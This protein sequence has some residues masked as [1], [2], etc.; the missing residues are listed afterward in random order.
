MLDDDKLLTG[1][2]LKDLLARWRVATDDDSIVPA[3]IGSEPDN[4]FRH[5]YMAVVVQ[6]LADLEVGW[7]Y[8]QGYL[9]VNFFNDGDGGPA[10]RERDLPELEA[11]FLKD[12]PKF[13]YTSTRKARLPDWW[14]D[15]ANPG[16]IR[17]SGRDS[18]YDPYTGR[19]WRKSGPLFET[20][21]FAVEFEPQIPFSFSVCCEGLGL[22]TVVARKAVAKWL[23]LRRSGK[24]V[25]FGIYRRKRTLDTEPEIC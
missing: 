16:H 2:S 22:R 20:L 7:D 11:W 4:E 9:K 6:A 24:R 15:S 21:H 14:A 1:V 23:E 3:Q 18:L 19:V 17:R 13:W 10:A 8:K 25:Q 5:Y 12:N